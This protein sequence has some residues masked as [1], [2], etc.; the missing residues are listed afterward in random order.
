MREN[1]ALFLEMNGALSGGRSGAVPLRLPRKRF[2]L[3]ALRLGL[4]GFL[5]GEPG[6]SPS[7]MGVSGMG[8]G[9]RL[10]V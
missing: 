2:F 7:G 10:P 4:H 6:R 9:R 8:R 3:N 1:M 5:Y